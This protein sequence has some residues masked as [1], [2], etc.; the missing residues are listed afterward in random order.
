M[1]IPPLGLI[2]SLL[3]LTCS[4][5]PEHPRPETRDPRPGFRDASPRWSPDGKRIAFLRIFG[6]R[7]TQL[8]V[9]DSELRNQRAITPIDSVRWARPPITG[10]AAPV[11]PDAPSWSPDSRRI[12]VSR[13]ERIPFDGRRSIGST[14]LW[15][16]EVDSGAATPI[17][18]HPEGYDGDLQ[19]YRAP[20]WS[21]DAKRIA[22]LAEGVYGYASLV[23][24][25]LGA[26]R[27]DQQSPP[28][29]MLDDDGWPTWSPDGRW[30]AFRHSLFQSES[31]LPIETIRLIAP[32]TERSRTIYVKSPNPAALWRVSHIAWA[33][34]SKGLAARTYDSGNP[35]KRGITVL[36]LQ[37]AKRRVMW[38]PSVD[39]SGLVWPSRHASSRPETLPQAPWNG[40]V[41]RIRK[42]EK[43]FRLNPPSSGPGID[44]PTDDFDISPD[45]IRIV[46]SEPHKN[47]PAAPTTLRVLKLSLD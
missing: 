5:A 8:W 39:S 28:V 42:T 23:V 44:I 27:P 19:F 26:T 12:A 16:Y 36:D 32:G 30:L 25:T 24:H 9:A 35:D 34:N 14:G 37:T 41:L 43:G 4:C 47:R 18:V 17:A 6:H 7:L 22:Y 20:S 3:A 2:S 11:S 45:G 15:A 21:P 33:P 40:R 10:R 31:A 13:G 29:D 46:V 38:T 1:R